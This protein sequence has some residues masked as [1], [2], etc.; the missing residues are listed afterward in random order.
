[1]IIAVFVLFISFIA[2]AHFQDQTELLSKAQLYYQD[3]A[4][5]KA[6]EIYQQIKPQTP[7]ILYNRGNVAYKMHNEKDAVIFWSR[8]AQ[9]AQGDLLK[10]ALSNRD[11]VLKKW[12]LRPDS[13]YKQWYIALSRPF[14]DIPL[15]VWQILFLI[16]L[17]ILCARSGV[18]F[19]TGRHK[20]LICMSIVC[21]IGAGIFIHYYHRKNLSIGFVAYDN[22]AMYAGP[23]EQYQVVMPLSKGSQVVVLSERDG[24]SKVSY[25][26]AIGWV[27]TNTLAVV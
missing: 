9:N 11:V 24:F 6:L 18:W 4:Y 15:I 17:G 5:D 14:N 7:A 2:Q 26:K 22:V 16:I 25:H 10:A 1:M 27:V 19:S 13:R 21:L 20:I 12:G 3:G 8:A 23:D